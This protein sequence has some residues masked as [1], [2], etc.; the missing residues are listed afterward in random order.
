MAVE[1]F[2]VL[3]GFLLAKTYEKRV[4]Q[5]QTSLEKCQT[6]C[7]N[8]FMRLW[9]EY[10]VSMCV[11]IILLQIFDKVNIQPFGLNVV[12]ISAIGGV[13]RILNNSRYVPVVS[14]RGCLLISLLFLQ[15]IKQKFLFCRFCFFV[16]IFYD[17]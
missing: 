14:W 17:K 8:H 2:F 6:Y 16:F 12:M 4:S 7:T 11:T 9:P 3:S 10:L 5:K 13:P 1:L 15:K